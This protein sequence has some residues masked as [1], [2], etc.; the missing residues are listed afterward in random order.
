[1]E[2][3]IKYERFEKEIQQDQ[4]QEFFDEL[5]TKGWQIIHYQEKRKEPLIPLLSIIIVA[6]KTSTLVKNVL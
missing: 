3:Y 5:I 1:M 2:A 6:G 4:L